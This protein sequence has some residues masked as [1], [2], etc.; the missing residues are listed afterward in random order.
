MYKLQKSWSIQ[1]EG[2]TEAKN[3]CK[4]KQEEYPVSD[5]Q[6]NG[7]VYNQFEINQKNLA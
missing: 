6:M 3:F 7:I 2:Q 4:P 5:F 1:L